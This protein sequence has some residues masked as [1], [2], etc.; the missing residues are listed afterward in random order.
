MAVKLRVKRPDPILRQIAAGLGEYA[1]AHPGAV[2]E[3]YRQNSV[4]VRVR[5]V[6]PAFAGKS[7]AQ[8]EDEVWAALNDLPEEAVAEISLLLL[9]TPAEAMS[10]FANV[11]FDDPIP[12]KL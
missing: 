8:R 7:R 12:S 11:E 5:V 4:S 2:I 1:D 6:S 10:S 9:L 3:A